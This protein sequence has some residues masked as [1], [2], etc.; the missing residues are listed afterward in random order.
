MIR[1]N[2]ETKR[3]DITLE[4][5]GS[6]CDVTMYWLDAAGRRHTPGEY[7][8]AQVEEAEVETT[9]GK[10]NRICVKMESEGDQ[11]CWEMFWFPDFVGARLTVT[12]DGLAV[13]GLCP[14][15]CE[16]P[17]WEL[18]GEELRALWT[19]FDNDKWVRFGSYP[20]EQ[21]KMGYWVSALYQEKGKKGLVA[22]SLQ[23]DTWKTGVSI[24]ERMKL[25]AGVADEE[26]RDTQPHGIVRGREVSSPMV[27]MIPAEDWR[28]GLVR[29]GELCACFQPRLVWN[30]PLIPGWNSWYAY[31][32]EVSHGNYCGASDFIATLQG[33]QQSE[34][35]YINFDAFWNTLSP[36]E[37]RDAVSHVKK[38][39]Q[40][41]GIYCAPFA[42][43]RKM[44]QMDDLVTDENGEPIM[45]EGFEGT[46]WYDVLQKAPD[47]NPLP[48]LA[49]GYPM[50]VTHPVVLK[51]LEKTIR[52]FGEMG[53]E[54]VKADFLCHG[55]ME[56]SHYDK[57]IQT[58]LQAYNH[59]MGVL[60]GI[61]QEE[62]L[63]VSLSIAPIFPHGYGHARRI[64]CDV[65]EKEKD[66]EY[67]LNSLAYGFWQNRTVYEFTDPDHICFSGS[68]GEAKMRYLSAAISGGMM[69]LSDR[70]EDGELS[71]KT[72]RITGK[73]KILEV[74][75]RHR[76]FWPVRSGTGDRAPELFYDRE[77][78]GAYLALFNFQGERRTYSVSL[79]ELGLNAATYLCEN[80]WSGTVFSC[81]EIF[82][83]DLDAG[84]C[85][86]V[87]LD[88]ARKN[89]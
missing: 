83:M 52:F 70:Y 27:C 56:G 89:A 51:R 67:E 43:W 78:S 84:D 20:P 22:G 45:V 23:H 3:F 42:A 39:G 11:C 87:R 49:G 65:F 76:A 74:A 15:C 18:G 66:S 33:F 41:P 73:T 79:S 7:Q 13:A 77:G 71:E 35:P 19:P 62:G 85:A 34:K 55:A 69:L 10:A 28:D 32:T 50:D 29:Y 40:R 1:W 63:F 58:G 2:Q 26:T 21:A 75:A 6:F 61:A 8:V 59:A 48:A 68:F 86:I 38:N 14:L 5:Y 53:F 16:A 25:I 57:R 47:G 37:L 54:Y 64:C 46:T 80:L 12:G 17:Q 30:R 82:C 24:G 88:L 60:S 31:G 9:C 72:R 81:T 44:E 36:E 4:G